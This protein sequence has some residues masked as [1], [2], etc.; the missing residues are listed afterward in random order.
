MLIKI[1]FIIVNIISD[2]V[3][4]RIFKLWLLNIVVVLFVKVIR[5]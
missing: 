5:I 3:L 2:K 1:E 4:L